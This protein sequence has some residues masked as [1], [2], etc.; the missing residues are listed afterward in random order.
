MSEQKPRHYSDIW[1]YKNYWHNL[2]EAEEI[3]QSMKQKL[4]EVKYFNAETN[5]ELE[6]LVDSLHVHLYETLMHELEL[7]DVPENDTEARE[8]YDHLFE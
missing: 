3:I 5:S 6:S 4:M 7:E 8:Y 2:L 1:N